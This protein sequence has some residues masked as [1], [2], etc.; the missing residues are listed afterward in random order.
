MLPGKGRHIRHGRLDLRV[1]AFHAKP[2][3]N[4]TPAQVPREAEAK[5][6]L[7]RSVLDGRRVLVVLDNARDAAQVAPL[8]PG[9]PSWPSLPA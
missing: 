7:Y 1:Q 9:A 8:L 6:A 3:S 4:L 5:S 2:E